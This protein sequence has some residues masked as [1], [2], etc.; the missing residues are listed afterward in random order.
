MSRVIADHLPP[1]QVRAAAFDTRW[2]GLHPGQVRDYLGRVAD[3]LERLHRE[4]I[5]ATT[6][7]ERIRRALIQWQARHSSRRCGPTTSDNRRPR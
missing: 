4:L 2:R 6:E 1:S 7:T 5:T 3:E